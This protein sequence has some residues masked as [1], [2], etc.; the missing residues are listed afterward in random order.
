MA[1]ISLTC[2]VCGRAVW[3]WDVDKQGRCCYCLEAT[4]LKRQPPGTL[5]QEPVSTPEPVGAEIATTAG[6]EAAVSTRSGRRRRHG[7]DGDW[8]GRGDVAP[9]SQDGTQED[10]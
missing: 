3:E 4:P 2:S 1:Y 7:P 10:K 8:P 9:V 5:I 6:P